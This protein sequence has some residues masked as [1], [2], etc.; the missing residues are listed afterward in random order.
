[1]L[2]ELRDAVAS[3]W[4]WIDAFCINQTDGPEIART[5]NCVDEIY[6]TASEYHVVGLESVS[7]GWCLREMGINPP[8]RKMHVHSSVLG[9]K[10]S[11]MVWLQAER[12]D[13][14]SLTFDKCALSD[15]QDRELVQKG[16]IKRFSTLA[17]FD[18]YVKAVVV[19]QLPD[20]AQ[21]LLWAQRPA[22]GRCR[23]MEKRGSWQVDVD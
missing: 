4:V 11:D 2:A 13:G 17:A 20:D 22:G 21:K 6:V 18:D 3:P 5:L 1:M 23:Q 14:I 9:V 10:G 7:R 12:E 8:Q 15:P 19:P 16:I